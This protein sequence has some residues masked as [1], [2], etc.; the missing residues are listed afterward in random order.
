[1]G[2][3]VEATVMEPWSNK[4]HDG[5]LGH[6]HVGSWVNLAAG[7]ITGNLKA[8]Y[9]PVRLHAPTADGGRTTIHTGRQFLGALVG[10]LVKTAVNTSLPCGARIGVAATVGGSPPDSVAA[11]TNMVV[12]GGE[13]STAEQVTIILERM[14]DRRGL[15][16]LEADRDL[17]RTLAAAP[18]G[19]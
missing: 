4:P 19:T 13:R 1:V 3:E 11:F 12:P 14:M 9:G 7:T 15:E 6:S 2:G 8:T 16:L 5:F 18:T 10:D 17:L